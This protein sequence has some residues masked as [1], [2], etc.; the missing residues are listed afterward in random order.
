[1][2]SLDQG[3]PSYI[4]SSEGPALQEVDME[5]K[6]RLAEI[7][8]SLESRLDGKELVKFARYEL[9]E[10]SAGRVI[11]DDKTVFQIDDLRKILYTPDLNKKEVRRILA[12]IAHR[13]RKLLEISEAKTRETK[14]SMK[15]TLNRVIFI[16]IF[17]D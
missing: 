13:A 5:A 11:P 16:S 4:E 6:N 2:S 15:F 1:M 9:Q 10:I 12:D 17:S 8:A 7:L 3:S 14:R